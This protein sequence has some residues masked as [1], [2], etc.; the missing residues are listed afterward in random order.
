[1]DAVTLASL[2]TASGTLLSGVGA[3]GGLFGGGGGPD[4][5]FWG[6]YWRDYNLRKA[7]FYQPIQT[8]VADA[9][10][11]GI[12]P[13]FALGYSG[14][15][16]GGGVQDFQ[17]DVAADWYDRVGALGD[18]L[19]QMGVARSQRKMQARQMEM[20]E[21]THEADLGRTKAETALIAAQAAQVL[22]EQP[23]NTGDSAAGKRNLY[24]QWHDNLSGQDVWLPH[25]DANVEMPET[26]GAGYWAKGKYHD[27]DMQ[28]RR[29]IQWHKGMY[30]RERERLRR[31]VAPPEVMF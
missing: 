8:R 25:E 16:G 7:A 11:A 24:V 5:D 18:S 12:H 31:K 15:V 17:P 6:R 2:L 9:E 4:R 13:L 10:A 30:R 23:G 21:E 3:V 28:K 26:V 22:T 1:M 27:P 19:Q 20:A 29:E 14:N